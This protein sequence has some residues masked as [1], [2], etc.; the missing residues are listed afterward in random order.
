MNTLFTAIEPFIYNEEQ[1]A[2]I[3]LSATCFHIKEKTPHTPL[4]HGSLAPKLFSHRFADAYP[5]PDISTIGEYVEISEEP[6]IRN[7]RQVLLSSNNITWSSRVWLV[8]FD[9]IDEICSVLSKTKYSSR[10]IKKIF[11]EANVLMRCARFIADHCEVLEE[12]EL[13]GRY[14]DPIIS[15]SHNPLSFI[16]QKRK[17]TS[18]ICYHLDLSTHF[19]FPLET[20]CENSAR[21]L[22]Y[23]DFRL[24]FQILPA[25]LSLSLSSL[26]LSLISICPTVNL[27]IVIPS[28]SA[29]FFPISQCFALYP[30]LEPI[31]VKTKTMS[32][33]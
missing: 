25:D 19:S 30:S 17:L 14:D 21:S 8:D 32:R 6:R 22:R 27:R 13:S 9:L 23:L 29:H 33:R 7:L 5:R 31:L 16:F 15:E 2:A 3:L 18:F 1:I 20:L 10:C 28:I 26:R 12:I 11:I 24:L 4:L